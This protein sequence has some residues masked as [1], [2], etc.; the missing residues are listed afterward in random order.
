MTTIK[1]PVITRVPISAEERALVQD[2][3]ERMLASPL[4]T[5]SKR[6][7]PFLRHVVEKTLDG[8]EDRLKERVLGSE[9]FGRAPDYDSNNDPVVRVTAG[10][11]RRRIA[12]YYDDSM[13]RNEFRIDLPIGTYVA[14]FHPGPPMDEEHRV[15]PQSTLLQADQTDPVAP[16]PALD[17][18][19][20]A[21]SPVKRLTA[22]IVGLAVLASAVLVWKFGHRN[23]SPVDAVWGNLVST[24]SSS[25]ISLGEPRLYPPE[26]TSD[27]PSAR[28]HLRSDYVTLSDLQALL[29]IVR[30]LDHKGAAYRV[31]PASSTSFADLRQGPV[32]LL[33][34]LDNPWTMRAQQNLRFG[35]Q[36]DG[37]GFDW[38]TDSRDPGAKKWFVDFNRPYSKVTTDYA[39][40]AYL[41]DP[42]TQQPTLIIAGMGENGTKAASEFITDDTQLNNALGESLRKPGGSNF[43]VVLSTEVVNGST[44]A[45]IVLVTEV[46]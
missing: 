19:A 18:A 11:V 2:Q 35:L 4:F 1:D 34:G 26:N 28:Q 29:R 31:Q 23:P 44:G 32:V 6:Y 36:S 42:G 14:Q 13:H 24:R 30:L 25:V 17:V 39:I 38:I 10:E 12:Q 43:E 46:W 22:A 37:N 33:G 45:P 3:L 9:L 8:Q 5:Q 27:E 41:R 40:V 15:I 20:P 16:M 7:A 21:H